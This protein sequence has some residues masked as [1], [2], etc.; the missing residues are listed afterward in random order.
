MSDT[1]ITTA[2]SPTTPSPLLVRPL[3]IVIP[4]GEGHLGRILSRHLFAK[5]HKLTTLTRNP[6]PTAHPWNT[7]QWDGQSPGSWTEVLED[8][9]VLIN[10]SGRSVDCRYTPAN[11]AE[12]LRSRVDSTIALGCAMQSL[13]H[14][15]RLWL[16]ASTATIYRHIYDRPMDEFT[17]EL[18]GEEPDAPPTWRF[19]IEVARQWEQAFLASPTPETRKIALRSAMVMSPESGGIF[20]IILRM[21]RAGLGGA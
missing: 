4:G 7:L 5:G 6:R 9:D 1:T 19:S 20:A 14:P 10:L 11:R 15:A 2:A 12:I 21:V 18:G 16:N 8:A 13:K 17:G 3:R